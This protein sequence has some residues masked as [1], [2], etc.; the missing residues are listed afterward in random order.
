VSYIVTVVFDTDV[1]NLE[2]AE[3]EHP[4]IIGG[5]LDAAKGRMI[6]HTRYVRAGFTMDIDEYESEEAYREFAGL[7]A[8]LIKRYGETAGAAPVDTLWERLG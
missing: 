8:P 3:Q 2:R 7:A 4:E 1:A 5:I 6:G